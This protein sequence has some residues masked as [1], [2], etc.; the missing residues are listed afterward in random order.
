MSR[1]A[2]I[3]RAI[4]A[5][6]AT[7]QERYEREKG[8]KRFCRNCSFGGTYCPILAHPMTRWERQS[9]ETHKKMTL[10]KGTD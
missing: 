8:K 5:K 1:L 7:A 3:V 6:G 9:D 2:A 4:G 10:R